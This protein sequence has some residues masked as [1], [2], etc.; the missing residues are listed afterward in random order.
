MVAASCRAAG[1]P[2]AGKTDVEELVVMVMTVPHTL[3]AGHKLNPG[4][5]GGGRLECRTE[6]LS[7]SGTLRW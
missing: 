5:A 1:E 7:S 2:G 6:Q 3:I 4:I